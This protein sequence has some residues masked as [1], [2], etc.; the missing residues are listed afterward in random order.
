M[1]NLTTSDELNYIK[2]A[3]IRKLIL[4]DYF[5]RVKDTNQ[6]DKCI[7]RNEYILREKCDE[8][9]TPLVV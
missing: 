1:K 5:C 8:I 9:Y 2:N 3:V 6:C 4:G 7:H